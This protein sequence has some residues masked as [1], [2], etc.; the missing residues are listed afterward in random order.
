MAVF[1]AIWSAIVQTATDGRTIAGIVSLVF[2]VTASDL[3]HSILVPTW[4]WWVVAFFG[5]FWTATR[6]NYLLHQQQEANRRLAPDMSLENLIERIVGS[7]VLEEGD[8]AARTAIAFNDIRDAAA[9]GRVSVW[10]R[11]NA[12]NITS[13]PRLLIG[14]EYWEFF[15]FNYLRYV[16][17]KAGETERVGLSRSQMAGREL[18]QNDIYS[19]IWFNRNEVDQVWPP[20]RKKRKFYNPFSRG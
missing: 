8:N 13:D 2:A 6:A 10:G 9:H 7:T 14:Q 15:G 20:R 4:V 1:K 5:V 17:N 11:K 12:T 19:D 3:G 16:A 18:I